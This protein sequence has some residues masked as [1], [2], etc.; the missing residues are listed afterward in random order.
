MD[1]F[2]KFAA[3]LRKLS[4]LIPDLENAIEDRNYYII[5]LKPI[6]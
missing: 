6:L 1:S 5:N 4:E 2:G 3:K